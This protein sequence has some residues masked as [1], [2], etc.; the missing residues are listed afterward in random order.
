MCRGCYGVRHADV[1]TKG[2]PIS[3][4]DDEYGR[5]TVAFAGLVEQ[6]AAL[7]L[8]D[9]ERPKVSCTKRHSSSLH[10]ALMR[11]ACLFCIKVAD[12]NDT[13]SQ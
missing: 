4:L 9:P 10:V 5:S 3:V 7:D 2:V 11:F 12:A 1:L 8:Y 6:F 13:L